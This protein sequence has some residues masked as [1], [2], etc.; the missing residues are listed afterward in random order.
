M[1]HT[2]GPWRI[3]DTKCICDM[4]IIPQW[5][6]NINKRKGLDGDYFPICSVS[7]SYVR[8][9]GDKKRFKFEHPVLPE[10][11]ALANAKLIA[12][13]PEL[14]EALKEITSCAK[15]A[16]PHGTTMYFI[17]DSRMNAAIDAIKKATT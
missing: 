3:Q 8:S 15:I 16:G 10:G 13:A 17:S 2:K 7:R 14:L 11:E 6:K 9:V 5:Q 4:T 1:K 12:A